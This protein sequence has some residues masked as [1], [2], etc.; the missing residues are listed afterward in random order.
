MAKNGIVD[1][2]RLAML[3]RR[4]SRY[5]VAYGSNLNLER[6]RQRCPS[7]KVVGTSV[8][9]GYRLLFKM[10][11]TGAYATIEQDANS[12]V[13][14]VVYH[15]SREDELRL[16]RFEGCPS[17]YY[18]KELMLPITRNNGTTMKELKPCAVYILHEH[19]LLGEPAVDYFRLLDE[20]Y[21][22]H[23][24][25]QQILD[26]GLADSIGYKAAERYIEDYVQWL[27]GAGAV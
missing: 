22:R 26:K 10:S 16:D 1:I 14:V 17:Y 18:K 13:P 6:M 27:T 20:G 7:C 23:G 21:A 24:F 5:V 2:Q 9:E 12:V 4:R 19:R 25:D 15:I 11:L 3:D 8:I